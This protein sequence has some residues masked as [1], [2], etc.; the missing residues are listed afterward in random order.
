MTHLTRVPT[1]ALV[2]LV[3]YV[4]RG[5]VAC[6]LTPVGLALAGLQDVSDDLLGSLRELD[7]R[8]VLAVLAAVLAERRPR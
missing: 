4:H 1:P 8:A 2:Q 7:R 6:P 5:Q 3:R